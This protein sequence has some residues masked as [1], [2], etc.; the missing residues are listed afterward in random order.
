MWARWLESYPELSLLD[1]DIGVGQAELRALRHV[2]KLSYWLLTPEEKLLYRALRLLGEN[3]IEDAAAQ[4]ASLGE[5]HALLPDLH[6]LAGALQLHYG[7]LEAACAHFERCYG[8]AV[9]PGLAL[10]RIQPCLRLLLRISP[11]VLLPLYPGSFAA[12][13]CLA[14]TYLALGR[15]GDALQ[16]AQEMTDAW[17]LYDEAKLL[18]GRAY[19]M[20]N[21]PARAESVLSVDEDTQHDALEL[22]RGLYLA[23]AHFQ[24]EEYRSAARALTPMLKTVKQANPHLLARARLLLAECYERSGLTLSALRESAQVA[25]GDVPGDVAREMLAREERW[26]VDLGGMSNREIER[27]THADT[28]QA[29]LPDAPRGVRKAGPL[30]ITRDPLKKL[31]PRAASWLKRQKE[32]REI[33]RVKAAVAR[34]ETVLLDN[35]TPLSAEGREVKSAVRA[36]EQ[37]WPSRRQ[38]LQQAASSARERLA[39]TDPAATGHLRFDWQG[40]RE[41]PVQLLIGEKR[42]AFLSAALTAVILLG[43]G[44]WLLRSCVY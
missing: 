5:E 22:G 36:A 41:E 31:K 39:H 6:L 8:A 14:A 10:R 16:V 24:L 20:R 30:E 40:Q 7:R 44:L 26:I 18:A 15:A 23:Y 12:A 17:G 32:L 25:P 4:L 43:L 34:G 13:C 28:Y 35:M 29:Y 1:L 9:D 21:D 42:M 3:R 19:I 2:T 33:E 11:C 27:L 38:A 37:W